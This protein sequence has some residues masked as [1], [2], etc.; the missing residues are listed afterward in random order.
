[1]RAELRRLAST[2]RS[3]QRSFGPAPPSKPC[4]DQ[5]VALLAI[6]HAA[7]PLPFIQSEY[8]PAALAAKLYHA[9]SDYLDV[10]LLELAR[11]RESKSEADLKLL[12]V[13]IKNMYT[14]LY[15]RKVEKASDIWQQRIQRQKKIGDAILDYA[16]QQSQKPSKADIK[17]LSRLTKRTVKQVTKWFENRRARYKNKPAKGPSNLEDVSRLIAQLRKQEVAP[18]ISLYFEDELDQAIPSRDPPIWVPLPALLSAPMIS[19]GRTASSWP[20]I[21]KIET[22]TEPTSFAIKLPPSKTDAPTKIEPTTAR[23]LNELVT[24]MT[25]LSLRHRVLNPKF[26]RAK[27]KKK[28]EMAAALSTAPPPPRPI[29]GRPS[30]LPRSA[31]GQSVSAPASEPSR[32][33]VRKHASSARRQP[34]STP[35]ALVVAHQA[36]KSVASAARTISHVSY[37][38]TSVTSSVHAGDSIFNPIILEPDAPIDFNALLT[39]LASD[40][41]AS[42]DAMLASTSEMSDFFSGMPEAAMFGDAASAA[43]SDTSSLAAL[44]NGEVTC[45]IRIPLSTRS[46]QLEA[47]LDGLLTAVPPLELDHAANSLMAWTSATIDVP[48]PGLDAQAVPQAIINQPELPTKGCFTQ[49]ELLELLNSPEFYELVADFSPEELD[50]FV[51]HLAV[52]A[53]PDLP[54][55]QRTAATPNLPED[56]ANSADARVARVPANRGDANLPEILLTPPTP[57]LP[58]F[59]QTAATPVAPTPQLPSDPVSF[60]PQHDANPI[61]L[62]SVS[63]TGTSN[64][65]ILLATDPAVLA[66]LLAMDLSVFNTL[67]IINPSFSLSHN[68][69]P[70]P[71]PAM[72]TANVGNPLLSADPNA[73]F[74]AATPSLSNWGDALSAP[75]SAPVSNHIIPQSQSVYD[76]SAALDMLQSFAMDPL[77]GFASVEP[78]TFPTSTPQFHQPLPMQQPQQILPD[79][80]PFTQLG[81]GLPAYSFDSMAPMESMADLVNP[82]MF[83]GDIFNRQ[84]PMPFTAFGA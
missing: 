61:T 73:F 36:P 21:Y 44:A 27:V 4:L 13:N 49:S 76:Q 18:G 20:T 78:T 72:P 45:L 16:W 6:R 70:F 42:K 32:A 51:E 33:R 80:F 37:A 10:A 66:S 68:P 63:P 12:A 11:H 48:P 77:T 23:A 5:D 30:Q 34:A 54:K 79:I 59:Q 1:M 28:K 38:P 82:F 53:T 71:V 35:Q 75:L 69:T 56:S 67:P 74:G 64:L 26:K 46:A 39:Q 55:F 17:R 58:E 14:K 83:T 41:Q 43:V 3:F 24:E 8:V 84:M 81:A 7:G 62:D 9:A 2:V 29:A 65:D 52:E 47:S 19:D 15:T 50:K 31:T 57:E 22:R 25:R 60:I 40:V